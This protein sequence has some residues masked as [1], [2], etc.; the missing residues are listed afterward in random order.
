MKKIIAIAVCILFAFTTVACT[1]DSPSDSD[2]QQ[3]Q[4]P[5]PVVEQKSAA[6]FEALGIT[7]DAPD[8]A[9]NI[10][11]SIIGG[12]LAEVRFT[13]GGNDYTY[14]AST[15]SDDISGVYDTFS[16]A[17]TLDILY[18]EYGLPVSAEADS[19]AEG[20]SLVTWAEDGVN[21]SL[22][23]ASA[24]SEAAL[25]GAVV[26]AMETVFSNVSE[27]IWTSRGIVRLA[28][29]SGL[30]CMDLDGDGN[31]ESITL[32]EIP[33]QEGELAMTKLVITSADGNASELVMDIV[34]VS[35]AFAVDIDGDGL[36]ELFIS[37]DE[38]SADYSTWMARYDGQSIVP[39]APYYEP[40]AEQTY[41]VASCSGTVE[42]FNLDNGSITVCDSV[43]IIGTWWCETQ[44]WLAAGT[45]ALERV[46]DS[47]WSNRNADYIDEEY[48]SYS[49]L[50]TVRELPYTTFDG[51]DAVLP[52]G[53]TLTLID[54]D[55]STYFR[56]LTQSGITGSIAVE[57][58]ADYWGVLIDGAHES[59]YFNDIPYA[60]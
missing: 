15:V 54:T 48:W 60:G 39:A 11:Y 56:F 46:P 41:Q 3:A 58:A 18:G 59:E 47:V 16:P 53:E 26:A 23:T 1:A 19:G 4:I 38:C 21:Y 42:D 9:E 8:G 2:G 24:V 14:R 10:V 25:R 20:G 45:F 33:E 44:Y 22:Y 28:K 36:V 17:F 55:Y 12:E 13:Y 50:V 52:I 27:D 51:A 57:P 30:T 5:N 34:Y 37:G 43:D 49:T 29:N 40:E 32:E 7:I 6:A 31:M 35:S